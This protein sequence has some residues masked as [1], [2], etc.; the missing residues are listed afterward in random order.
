L[1]CERWAKIESCVGRTDDI[2]ATIYHSLFCLL[3]YIF[4]FVSIRI[5]VGKFIE[6]LHVDILVAKWKMK[7][8]LQ[9]MSMMQNLVIFYKTGVSI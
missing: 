3:S 4:V 5:Q 7:R 8:I 6:Y 9:K 2:F 1:S